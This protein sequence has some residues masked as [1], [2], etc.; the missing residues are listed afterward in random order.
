MMSV[1]KGWRELAH[2]VMHS[3]AWQQRQALTAHNRGRIR[4]QAC[5]QPNCVLL[6]PDDAA[7]VPGESMHLRIGD[8][9]F[10]C[11]TSDQV[12]RGKLSLSSIQRR[13]L[14]MRDDTCFSED[15]ARPIV[16]RRVWPTRTLARVS[17]MCA[18]GGQH[19]ESLNPDTVR[20]AIQDNFCGQVL[21]PNMLLPLE[22]GCRHSPTNSS[23]DAH[24]N[25]FVRPSPSL[26]ARTGK[27][28]VIA[29]LLRVVAT[30]E[31]PPGENYGVLGPETSI[32]TADYSPAMPKRPLGRQERR[33]PADH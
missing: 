1:S 9:V 2:M 31:G 30:D 6:H 18:R 15:S 10:S 21:L 8:F 29:L 24:H 27:L 22:I 14:S 23:A 11:A 16:P 4:P 20:R 33:A 25:P 19:L 3:D 17:L 28:S 32:R 7:L 13:V 12:P 5:D 26:S